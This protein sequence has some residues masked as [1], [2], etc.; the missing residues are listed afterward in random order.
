VPW[1]EAGKLFFTENS[2]LLHQ[3][4]LYEIDGVDGAPRVVIDPQQLSPDGAIAIRDFAVSPDGRWVAYSSSP[5]GA[6]IGD[7]HVRALAT[8]REHA[9]VVRG[10]VSNVCWTADGNGFFYMRPPASAAWAGRRCGTARKAVLL[11]PARHAAGERSADPRVADA[12]WLY[13]MLERRRAGACSWSSSAA[14]TRGCT[15][16]TCT[17]RARPTVSAPLV[18]LLGDVTAHHTPMGTVGDTLYAWT[19]LDAPHGRIIALDLEGGSR[20]AAA[21]RRCPSRPM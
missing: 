17:T 13:A 19:D 10:T 7:T 8:G 6:D 5:G 15:C 9:D 12:R 11:S 21:D 20:R 3:P 1:R 16:S 4:I 18:P 2:G 14:R